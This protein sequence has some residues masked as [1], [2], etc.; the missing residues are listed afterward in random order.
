[1]S[2]AAGTALAKRLN[3]DGSHVNCMTSDGEWQEGSTWESMIF[4]CHHQQKNTSAH[5]PHGP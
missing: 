4:L 1:L 3:A 5:G 2:L